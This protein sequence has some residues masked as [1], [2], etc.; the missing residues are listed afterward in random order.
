MGQ[1]HVH[2]SLPKLMKRIQHGEVITH[3][4]RLDDAPKASATR[5]TTA[6]STS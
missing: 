4:A 2:R 5:R 3:R 6:A 1:T